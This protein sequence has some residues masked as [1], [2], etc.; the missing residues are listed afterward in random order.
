MTAQSSS[1]ALSAEASVGESRAAYLD[2][3]AH[4]RTGVSTKT[5]TTTTTN[6]PPV[7]PQLWSF[8][9][10]PERGSGDAAADA[11]NS[12]TSAP[13]N[14]S[15]QVTKQ[16]RR[17]NPHGL[18]T[19]GPARHKAPSSRPNTRDAA[20]ASER[21]SRTSQDE[22][23]NA[24]QRGGAPVPS[25]AFLTFR[26]QPALPA[27]PVPPDAMASSGRRGRLPISNMAVPA[28]KGPLAGAGGATVEELG[29]LRREASGTGSPNRRRRARRRGINTDEIFGNAH[30]EVQ[31]GQIE[32]ES[33]RWFEEKVKLGSEEKA[34]TPIDSSREELDFSLPVE[35]MVRALQ[36][37]D[38]H[39]RMDPAM[40]ADERRV[41]SMNVISNYPRSVVL[42]GKL[43]GVGP[44][45]FEPREEQE[46]AE[47]QEAVIT[48]TTTGA[49]AKVKRSMHMA[50]RQ[51]ANMK[52]G[53]HILNWLQDGGVDSLESRARTASK[54]HGE[55]VSRP[56]LPKVNAGPTVNSVLID[57]RELLQAVLNANPAAINVEEAA[58]EVAAHRDAAEVMRKRAGGPETAYMGHEQFRRTSYS[59]AVAWSRPFFKMGSVPK[60]VYVRAPVEKEDVVVVK[61]EWKLETSIFNPRPSECD[62]KSFFDTEK[63]RRRRLDLDW[64]RVC[65]KSRFVSL[66]GKADSDVARGGAQSGGMSDA[67]K[68]ELNEV[69]EVIFKCFPTICASYSYFSLMGTGIGEAA[70]SMSFN[71]WK[72]FVRDC[73]M[74]DQKVKGCRSADLDTMFVSSNF[75]E[76]KKSEMNQENDDNSLM[77][78]E[79]LEILVRVAIARYIQTKALDDV[80]EAVEELCEKIILPNLCDEALVIPDEFRKERMYFEEV[81]QVL[82]PHLRWLRALFAMFV[83]TG[84]S[85]RYMEMEPFFKL[86]ESIDICNAR[87][88]ISRSELKL[89][90]GWCTMSPADELKRERLCGLS[91]VDFLEALC[92][93]ADLLSPVTSETLDEYFH[94]TN[95]ADTEHRTAEFYKEAP[96][97]YAEETRRDSADIMAPKTRPL[98]EKVRGLLEIMSIRVLDKWGDD[99]PEM[100]EVLPK[101]EVYA[102]TAGVDVKT[103][104]TKGWEAVVPFVLLKS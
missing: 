16:Q 23:P 101:L 8:G 14:M 56:A 43:E 59:S 89:I 32:K 11:L 39:A 17:L 65:E 45:S 86:M 41:H 46:Q 82:L 18:H 27:L 80:S 97:D 47:V 98:A 20:A 99:D 87:T 72:S 63:V 92:R 94:E 22:S 35:S 1:V 26:R 103:I 3:L 78:F 10:P 48:R 21:K 19:S 31:L 85:R 40:A 28:W 37:D 49:A 2:K 91:W 76:D 77:R 53:R 74:E 66:I 33:I 58:A 42:K 9:G 44:P 6:Q 61:V 52:Q 24:G 90:F 54:K 55:V 69:K 7:V 81:Q 25:E 84:T 36:H 100:S 104:P 67:L 70:Y 51:L 38:H 34:P 93:V 12:A 50:K 4:R 57:E 71:Q 83:G 95:D 64:K 73:E 62:A 13:G 60:N 15:P 102:R 75:E 30:L 96:E 79:F 29:E 5:T 68:E 88:G